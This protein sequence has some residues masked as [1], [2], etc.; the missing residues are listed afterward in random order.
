[1]AQH[2]HLTAP[3]FAAWN[4]AAAR[5]AAAA[6]P[7]AIADAL[8]DAL[9]VVLDFDGIFMAALHRDAPPSVQVRLLRALG[10][11][12]AAC[13]LPLLAGWPLPLGASLG[14]FAL[15]GIAIAGATLSWSCAKEVN[16]PELAGT[17]TSVVNTGGFLGPAIYQPLVGWVLDLSSGGSTHSTWDWQLALG[18]MSLFTF[19]GLACAF[20]VRE[21]Y[22]H[23]VYGS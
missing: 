4:A 20:L 10:A 3:E 21:T 6:E 8:T 12:Y 11:L 2:L 18:A 15:M 16:P 17:A 13:W 14:L 23:G 1:M 7:A 5:A 22:C 19:G 9:K